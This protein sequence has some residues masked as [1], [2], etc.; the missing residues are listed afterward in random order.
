MIH[1]GGAL[2]VLALKVKNSYPEM[3]CITF[4]SPHVGNLFMSIFSDSW[5]KTDFI[6]MGNIIHDWDYPGKALLLKKSCENLNKGGMF[7]CI[8]DF[9]EE[10]R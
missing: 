8:E 1:V 6:F 4:D 3:H 2:G 5:P 7:V 10:K 9:L